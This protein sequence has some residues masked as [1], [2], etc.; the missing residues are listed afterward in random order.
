MYY[1]KV[2]NDDEYNKVR[3]RFG[4]TTSS[5]VQVRTLRHLGLK[6]EFKTNGKASDLERLINEGRPVPV[7]WLHRGSVSY[8]TGGGHWTVVIGHTP[9]SWIHHDPYGEAFLV[10]GQYAVSSTKGKN[11]AYSRKNWNP[12]WMVRGTGGWYLDISN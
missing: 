11:I 12:R 5:D 6:A 8:P 9:T 2:K 4:D 7:G 1:G 10:N 3:A